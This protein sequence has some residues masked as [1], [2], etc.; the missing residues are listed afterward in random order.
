MGTASV[1][2]AGPS[3]RSVDPDDRRKHLEF[4]QAA[5]SRQAGNSF[6]V[7]GWALTVTAAAYG[8]AATQRE[9]L[10]ALVGLAAAAGFWYLDALY[11]RQER[12]YRDLYEDLTSATPTAEPYS[13]RT[14]GT[15][16]ARTKWWAVLRGPSVWPLF[17]G[18]AVAGVV[19]SA[20]GWSDQDPTACRKDSANSSSSSAG[21][22]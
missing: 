5:V 20:V 17:L 3:P 21:T 22:G 9:P 19:A 16:T 4:V 13:M 15:A 12:L 1:N 8:F 10:V 6:L 18:L 2:P 7:K 11:L 14:S